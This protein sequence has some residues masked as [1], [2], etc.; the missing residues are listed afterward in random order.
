[1]DSKIMPEIIPMWISG[2]DQIMNEYRG[3]PKPVPRPG[4][5]ISI[6]VGQPITDRIK[7][8]VDEWRR[9]VASEKG[10]LGV[11]GEWGTPAS[12]AALPGS[13]RSPEL[14]SGE[15]AQAETGAFQQQ[16]TRSAG[17]LADGRERSVRIR[18]TEAIQEA[19]RQL[20][21]QV[22]REEGRFE[23]REWCQ[24]TPGVHTRSS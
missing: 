1:M 11:G 22:E 23:R 20:G 14:K 10:A 2:F 18:I 24:S 12:G 15:V 6:T 21:E 8:L 3:S 7:P 4:A 13:E 19:V 5:S 17:E 9:I 16:M